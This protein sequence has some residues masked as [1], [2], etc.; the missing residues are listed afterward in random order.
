M[1]RLERMGAVT[2]AYLAISLV[3]TVG[4]M[5]LATRPP[6][7]RTLG[8]AAAGRISISDME[9]DVS[10]TFS[11]V[12][13]E[14]L[15]DLFGPAGA[16]RLLGPSGSAGEVPG[17]QSATSASSRSPQPPPREEPD[18]T[19]QI[20]ERP[21]LRIEMSVDKSEASAGETLRY[22]IT[23]TNIGRGA[24]KQFSI[25]SHVPE[26]TTLFAAPG[27]EGPG[28]EAPPDGDIGVCGPGSPAPGE[29]GVKDSSVQFLEPGQ[30]A[31]TFF[32]V[33]VGADAPEGFVIF[34]HAHVQGVDLPTRTSNEVSTRVR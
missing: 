14:I 12:S 28:V 7:L 2:I 4:A 31:T 18:L 5:T 8:L 33:L 6:G 16:E 27:C 13:P 10:P 9:A 32:K 11:P 3:A 29:H 19:E 26:H 24:T 22:V 23:V 21:D 20:T 30:S 15:R 34:N 25:T 17:G 1:R